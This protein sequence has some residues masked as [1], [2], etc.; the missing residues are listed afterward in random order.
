MTDLYRK[1][2]LATI[3]STW[4]YEIKH[5]AVAALGGGPKPDAWRRYNEVTDAQDGQW[6]YWRDP[7]D[8]ED[9]SADCALVEDGEIVGKGGCGLSFL[10]DCQP[11]PVDTETLAALEKADAD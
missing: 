5:L 4:N 9:V 2:A 3:E 10:T 11:C 6:F 7:N 1:L 8:P